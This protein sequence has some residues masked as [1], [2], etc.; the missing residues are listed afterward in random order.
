MPDEK[1]FAPPIEPVV[2]PQPP[3]EWKKRQEYW[4]KQLEEYSKRAETPIEP[5]SAI[6][7][8]PLYKPK[9]WLD[10]LIV[11]LGG[12]FKAENIWAPIPK[13]VGTTWQATPLA[14][15]ERMRQQADI[16]V[17]SS[18]RAQFFIDFYSQAP[19]LVSTGRVTSYED[20]LDVTG[21]SG[22]LLTPQDITEA[23]AAIESIAVRG[24]ELPEW[25][26]VSPEEEAAVREFLEAGLKEK[27]FPLASLNRLTIDEIIKALA[28][29]VTTAKLPE[30]MS[31]EELLRLASVMDLPPESIETVLD[32]DQA[33]A[34]IRE[35]TLE[36]ER[37]IADVKAGIRDWEPPD[38]SFWE[39]AFFVVQSPMQQFADLIKPYLEHFAYPWAGTVSL[40]V[41]RGMAGTQDLE[42]LFDKARAEGVDPWHAAGV[43][44]E[45]WGLPLYW[46]LPI[47][48]LIDPITY[49]PGIGLAVTGKIFTKVGLKTF[50]ESLI[51]LNRGMMSALDI[52]FDAAKHLLSRF[53]KTTSQIIRHELDNFTTTF[54]AAVARQTGKAIHQFTKEDVAI[55]LRSA[56]DAFVANPKMDGNALVDLG[57]YLS[58]HV[59]MTEKQI[60]LWSRTHGGKLAEDVPASVVSEVNQV[61]TD[62]ITKVGSHA[63]NAKR[64][65]RALMVEETPENITKLVKEI[66]AYSKKLST[67][68]DTVIQIGRTA[69]IGPVA[70]MLN[71]MAVRQKAV[72][73][74][75]LAG[76]QESGS[77][78]EGIALGLQRSVDKIENMRWRTVLDRY[79][80]R[81]FAEANL[82]SIAYPIWNAFEGIA[83]S[84]IEGVTPRFVKW[85]AYN[86]MVKGLL[87]DPK[88]AAQ[89]ASDVAGI[90]GTI[91]GRR[92]GAISLLP[93]IIP[94]RI[95][96]W[97]VS[98]WAAG[99]DWLEWI[100]RK[101]IQISDVVGNSFRRNYV[102]QKYARH[103]AERAYNV[104]G[105]DI[106]LALQKLIKSSPRI[107][108]QTLG[109]TQ[110]E[111]EQE[112]FR[113]LSVSVE[114]VLALKG[115][116][117]DGSLMQGET[118]KILRKADYLSPRAKA[119]GE[120]LIYE[121]KALK[122]TDSIVDFVKQVSD[123][124]I[125]DLRRYPF[126]VSES[127]RYVANKIEQTPIKTSDNLMEIFTHYETMSETAAFIP[128][129]LMS[130]V[131]DEA[132][133]LYKAGK[134]GQIDPL[135][136][137]ARQSLLDTME[138]ITSSLATVKNKILANSDKL[139]SK[140]RVAMESVLER[141]EASNIIR[142][143]T[144]RQDGQ[145]LDDFFALPKAMRTSDEYTALRAYRAELWENYRLESAIPSAGEFITRRDLAQLYHNLPEPKLNSIDASSR[146]LSSQDVADVFGVNI[147]GLASGMLDN[148]A[149]HGKPYFIQL[150]K[151]SAE[152]RPHLFK[153]FTE[154]K[155]A[156]VYDNILVQARMRPDVDI[157]A[158]K[159]LQQAEGVKQEL[160]SLKMRHSLTPD[161]EKALHSWIDNAAAGRE[162]VIGKRGLVSQDDWNKL[163]QESLDEANKD[164]YKAFADYTN[165][166][167]IGA[168]MKMIYPYW[169]YHTYR[170]F[171]LSRTALRHPGVPAAWGKYQNYG[172]HGFMPT[173]I[174][175]IEANPFI[176]S[177]MGTT[178]TL[179]RF[180]FAS[181]YENLGFA[182]EIL[183]YTQ[184]WGFFPGVH[185][186]APIALT[187]YFSDRPFEL[188]DIMP[189]IGRTGINLLVASDIPGVASAAKWLKDKIFHE[190]FHEYY[191]STI[192]DNKQVEAGGTLIEGQTGTDLWFKKLRGE[193]FTDE[194]QQLWDESYKDAAL[195]GTLRSQFPQF[196]LKTEDYKEAYKQ[197]TRLFE[198]H[199]GMS[200]AFQK[201]L[202]RHHQRPT[203][204]VGG[205]PLDLR[206]ALDELWQWKIY[207]GRGVILN[208][209]EVQDLKAEVDKY[210]K[211]V[212]DY[213]GD[214]LTA[215][216]DIDQGFIYP[217]KELH[218]DGREW[219]V[220]YAKNWGDYSSKTKK[221]K[222]DKEFAD[223]V[224]AL[225]PEG[226][227]RLAKRLGFNVTPTYPLDEAINLYFDIK[228]EK[229]ADPISGEVDWD[230]LTFWLKR[231]AVRM[232]L[233][234]EQRTDFDASIRKYQTPMEMTFRHIYNTYIRGYKASDRI[235]FESYNDE[236]KAIIKEFYADTTTRVRSGEIREILS[237]T[238]RKLIAEYES[239]RSNARL[240]LRQVSPTLDFYLYVFGY[241]S[242]PRTPETEAMVDKWEADRSSILMK[243]E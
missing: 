84:L 102:V 12:G 101:W 169:T 227:M 242:K 25:L 125:D 236:Q 127:F 191:T 124:A 26:E 68:I 71:Y 171:F 21:E 95:L 14:V 60:Y 149:M 74:S 160:V 76:K 218:F 31:T 122:D 82:G 126:E 217:T 6:P 226:Q 156:Q 208:P 138:D 224:E 199:L 174:P 112:M 11:F 168:T 164:Y 8:V 186:I 182:G 5:M 194:E 65:A 92:A 198:E 64:M 130:Q 96:G 196:R 155:I 223:A 79:V 151:Q 179:T 187:S 205:L 7:S 78:L 214:R 140:Q 107:S 80:V 195:I 239:K 178:F 165:E 24:E 222:E 59:A 38:M 200:E 210:W 192:L 147:D 206:M 103:L 63:A 17:D 13:M 89:T 42:K 23:K 190:N 36:K 184:R 27:Q 134:F 116:L 67:N 133:I 202:W 143:T 128:H 117:T 120:Q 81:T 180:D 225:T 105:Q 162:K 73:A 51:S 161:E 175:N 193:N 61:I 159:I 28:P 44:W 15:Q 40:M 115:V 77:L 62:F 104:A 167:I 197:V 34:V 45:E 2:P 221:L 113:R 54:N 189:P 109:L 233:T 153:G 157:M 30:G 56:R 4:R 238:G 118:L 172:E 55:T 181:Y 177:V 72:S 58:E 50:G 83:V 70:R 66:P 166:N 203:D 9:G 49:T 114:D 150:V 93:G 185:V 145:L 97:N 213:Q 86:M 211:K 132:D 158:Q 237:D 240:A 235:M 33:V 3:V 119:I 129:R 16:A 207:F 87:G 90:F 111:L 201:E 232:A 29:P 37:M 106:N 215:Q 216:V 231:E 141:S 154:E 75:R 39:K 69:Q 32:I 99:K 121:G 43:S 94:E 10:R 183:D 52:P 110:H 220:E 19:L 243:Q 131:M 35:A 176:G 41:Q 100:G 142:E 20:Y 57:R 144:L 230:Y 188:G 163:R 212:K 53:P 229:K 47:E 85:E 46:K 228:L 173:P 234:E 146:A 123:A 135:W 209:P 48:I 108:K 170:W 219:R 18:V 241:I 139:T 204:V 152:S 137:K 98:K 88:L 22:S 1:G 148:I 136:R 91:S